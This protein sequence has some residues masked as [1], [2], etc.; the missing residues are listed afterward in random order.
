ML[1]ARKPKKPKDLPEG[2][3]TE[4]TYNKHYEYFDSLLDA[5]GETSIVEEVSSSKEIKKLGGKVKNVE[6][7]IELLDWVYDGVAHAS[8]N[9][10]LEIKGIKGIQCTAGE[11]IYKRAI[12]EV[13]DGDVE[14][15]LEYDDS[16]AQAWCEINGKYSI[17]DDD[18]PCGFVEDAIKEELEG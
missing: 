15:W 14:V 11:I 10:D 16:P 17:E 2:P 18:D 4:E 7:S 12:W 5:T 6:Y 9:A 8:V 1:E 3:V 13:E